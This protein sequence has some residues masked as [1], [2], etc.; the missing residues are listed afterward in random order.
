MH[1]V[2]FA[3]RHGRRAAVA[4]AFVS[5]AAAATAAQAATLSVPSARFATIQ[6]ALDA[7]RPGDTVQVMPKRSADGLWH[8]NLKIHTTGVTLQGKNGATVDG[9][10]LAQVIVHYPGKPY[11]YTEIIGDNGVTISADNVSV[12]GLTIQNFDADTGF[13]PAAG[14]AAPDAS[15]VSIAGNVLRRNGYGVSLPGAT[16]AAARVSVIGNAVSDSRADGITGYNIAGQVLVEGNVVTNSGRGGL[17]YSGISLSAVASAAIRAN[18]VSGNGDRG[19]SLDVDTFDG[20]AA[21]PSVVEFNVSDRNQGYGIE[22]SDFAGGR[23]RFNSVTRCGS[24]IEVG[25]GQGLLVADNYVAQN[26]YFGIEL[27]SCQGCQVTR[28]RVT[29]NNFGDDGS[30]PDEYYGGITTTSMYDDETPNLLTNNVALNNGNA[31][32]FDE[33]AADGDPLVNAWTGNRFGVANSPDI[34]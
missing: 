34:H 13:G 32:L 4:A 10:G 24:G 9:V 20:P 33:N 2:L 11:E 29:G 31:D 16:S 15:R 1:F 8:E 25:Y 6:S 26:K 14:V 18:V 27:Y 28:N 12:R 22:V 7:A 5:L 3:P 23:V 30:S 21:P 19:I 17:G